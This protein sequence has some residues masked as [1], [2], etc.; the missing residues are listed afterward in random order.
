MDSGVN[1]VIT[2][3]FSFIGPHL[4]RHSAYELIQMAKTGTIQIFGNGNA[5]R[6]Y[7]YGEDL[8]KWMW[9]ILLNGSGI[10][11]VGSEIPFTILELARKIAEVIP[12]K[13]EV[14]NQPYVPNTRY[15]PDVTWAKKLGCYETVSLTDA[16]KRTVVE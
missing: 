11:D 14:Q 13:I 2:R 4:K 10:Y 1:C 9:K 6:S 15:M 3:L 12:A 5:I 8:G 7:L 16:I